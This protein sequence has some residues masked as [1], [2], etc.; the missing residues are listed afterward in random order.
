MKKISFIVTVLVAMVFSASAEPLKLSGSDVLAPVIEKD[1]VSLAKKSDIDVQC[2]MAGTYLA[3]PNLLAG[4]TDVAII[5]LPRKQK[6]PEGL[7]ALP[8]AY[9]A[10]VVIVNSVNP[11]EE[12]TT[13]QL[14]D[15]FSVNAKVRSENWSQIGVSDVSLR[16]IVAVSTSFA[17]NLVVELFKAEALNGYNLGPWVNMASNKNNVIS[18]IKTN[19]SAIAIVGKAIEGDLVKILPVS[20]SEG[21]KTYAY[22]PDSE[23]IFNGDYALTLPFY[24]V[25][26]KENINKVK[27]LLK[28][29]LDDEIAR[30]LDNSDFYSAPK[31][32]RKKSI[33]E[34][35]IIK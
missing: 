8:F 6:L 34:L 1:V 32:S 20:K 10:T 25:F 5:A 12:I 11:I 30:L 22:K 3:M 14:H 18:I 33:F 23:S 19:N 24:I 7:V 29:L 26:K 13:K 27:P 31:N 4:K 21:S 17:D 35:D 9:Q 15:I 16:N 28:I 2:K